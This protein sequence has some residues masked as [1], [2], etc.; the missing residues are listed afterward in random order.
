MFLSRLLGWQPRT[1]TSRAQTRVGGEHWAW[2]WT[3]APTF[4]SRLLGRQWHH[5][6][7][8]AASEWMSSFG[9]MF[10]IFVGHAKCNVSP[11]DRWA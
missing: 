1:E 3:E 4:L 5:S 9:D 2:S 8:Q 7:S 11:E 10:E 6:L